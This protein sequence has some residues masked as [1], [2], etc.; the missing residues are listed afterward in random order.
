MGFE[1][2]FIPTKE[3]IDEK[4]KPLV[5]YKSDKNDIPY[6]KTDILVYCLGDYDETRKVMS[7]LKFNLKYL[8]E[9]IRLEVIQGAVERFE[10]EGQIWYCGWQYSRDECDWELDDLVGRTT[11]SLTIL[12]QS[13]K[14]P[15]Y[16]NENEL[17]YDKINKIDGEVDEFEDSC[18]DIAI[19]EVMN[20]LREFQVNDDDDGSVDKNED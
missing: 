18:R 2:D 17:F 12:K 7:R 1:I 16:F 14:T 4:L 20:M 11:K 8:Y 10:E 19:Y 5:K 15:D 9:I 13:V 3:F 6:L